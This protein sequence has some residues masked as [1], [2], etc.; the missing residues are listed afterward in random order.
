MRG[1]S[2]VCDGRGSARSALDTPEGG[3]LAPGQPP[4]LSDSTLRASGN[5]ATH[6]PRPGAAP[7]L[8]APPPR[9]P[10]A[11]P[12]SRAVRAKPLLPRAVRLLRLR[13]APPCVRG[14]PGEGAAATCC[15]A[16]SEQRLVARRCSPAGR[17]FVSARRLL[18]PPSVNHSW[19][20]REEGRPGDARPFKGAARLFRAPA[21]GPRQGSGSPCHSRPLWRK[22]PCV[23]LRCVLLLFF[24]R[25]WAS[26]G[27][28]NS[29]GVVCQCGPFGVVTFI[30][31]TQ[32]QSVS[33]SDTFLVPVL[34]I[35]SGSLG[36]GA[37]E[38]NG[39]G[40]EKT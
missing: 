38:G 1:S 6:S 8:A 19:S 12:R 16:P 34:A 31:N 13:P 24:C 27:P 2:L 3:G 20:P 10:H 33:G 22:G 32:S 4:G 11:P 9:G 37:K 29:G 21:P 26:S 17:T 30:I 14:F 5:S 7:R 15:D 23:A 28:P 35:S 40:V 18:S 39:G 25:L 36:L